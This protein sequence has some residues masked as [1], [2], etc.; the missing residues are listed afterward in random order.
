MKTFTIPLIFLIST[1]L[2]SACTKEAKKEVP[3]ISSKETK[4]VTIKQINLEPFKEDGKF[5]YK[6]NGHVFLLPQYDYAS[7]FNDELALVIQNGKGSFI[8][9]Y[10]E[11]V[12]HLPYE[13]VGGFSEGLISVKQNGKWGFINTEGKIII[14]LQYD[15]VDTFNESLACVSKNGKEGFINKQGEIVIP[16]IYE[17][18]PPKAM[19][20][21]FRSNIP[22]TPNTHSFYQGLYRAKKSNKYGIINTKGVPIVPFQYDRI[23][24]FFGDLALVSRDNKFGFI[25]RQ[26]ELIVPITYD[27]VDNFWTDKDNFSNFDTSLIAVKK[28][29]KWG[30]INK[31]GYLVVPLQYDAIIGFKGG[32]TM[33]GLNGKFGFINE[34]GEIIIPLKYDYGEYKEI[35]NSINRL[36]FASTVKKVEVKVNDSYTTISVD[37]EKFTI[38]KY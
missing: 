21:G 28:D 30:F 26:G 5:G 17:F 8:N 27:S 33:V 19:S 7:S 18:R 31:K 35:S 38:D 29:D 20:G 36:A 16:L 3:D 2:L 22:S 9:A 25:N 1:T 12:K 34:N 10:G 15:F 11:K 37:G 24:S 6:R 32:I 23:S 14:P 13:K 4:K